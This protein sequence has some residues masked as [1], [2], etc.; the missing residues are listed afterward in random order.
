[1]YKNLDEILD[2]IVKEDGGKYAIKTQMA[3]DSFRNTGLPEENV[4]FIKELCEKFRKNIFRK[5]D[6]IILGKFGEFGT[7]QI[8]P[9]ED[10]LSV[11]EPEAD[12]VKL[13]YTEKGDNVW[14]TTRNKKTLLWTDYSATDPCNRQ[15]PFYAGLFFNMM[16]FNYSTGSYREFEYIGDNNSYININGF[17]YNSFWK[18]ISFGICLETKNVDEFLVNLRK[19]SNK[20]V[21]E[22]GYADA[23][24]MNRMV[25]MINPW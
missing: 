11:D 9:A 1:M 24:S 20:Y 5:G 7:I 21:S 19:L 18:I 10:L 14:V 8:I 22:Q 23:K 2:D 12:N 6:T 15:E 25:L 13:S 16:Q 4:D 3:V 17:E